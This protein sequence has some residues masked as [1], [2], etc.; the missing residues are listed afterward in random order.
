[1]KKNIAKLLSYVSPEMQKNLDKLE[2][3]RT[4][5]ERAEVKLESVMDSLDLVTT[6]R[7]KQKIL[8]EAKA[9]AKK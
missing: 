3:I 4:G 9:E 7:E 6:G 5:M 2:K 8:N 1:M